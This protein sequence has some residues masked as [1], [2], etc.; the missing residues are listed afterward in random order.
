MRLALHWS[1]PNV[2]ATAFIFPRRWMQSPPIAAAVQRGVRFSLLTWTEFHSQKSSKLKCVAL[3][4]ILQKFHPYANLTK[5]MHSIAIPKQCPQLTIM[6]SN[7]LRSG[8]NT[9]AHATSDYACV[10]PHRRSWS[11]AALPNGR[12]KLLLAVRQLQEVL[13]KATT[14]CLPTPQQAW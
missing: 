1:P 10:L 14:A 12:A 5:K 11:F 3:R 4:F 9:S 8:K 2:R 6:I 7:W 13:C